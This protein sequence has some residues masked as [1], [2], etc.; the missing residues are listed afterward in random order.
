VTDATFSREVLNSTEPVIVDFWAPWCHPC[1]RM[2][3]TFEALAVEYQGK[4]RFA[5]LNTDENENTP[6]R[7]GIQGIPTMIFF[8]GGQEVDRIVG[9]VNRETLK[10]RLD[11]VLGAVA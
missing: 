6:M 10:R 8:R 5:K 2:A 11:A 3:P 1:L 4:I 7:Y 9:L